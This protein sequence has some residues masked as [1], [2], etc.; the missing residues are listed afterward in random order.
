MSFRR[1]QLSYFVTVAQEGQITRAARKLHMAQPALSQ[2][3][4]QL[5]SQLGV[6]LLERH[7]RGV[8][9]TEAG[10]VFLEKAKAAL[11]A[12]ADAAATGRSLARMA[13]GSI[14][15]G[16][17]STPPRMFAAPLFEGFARTH[18][19]VTVS[20]RELRFPSASTA[21]WLAEV[22]MA[23]CFSP[24]PDPGVVTQALWWEP[25]WVLLHRDHALAERQAVAVADVL[26]EPFYGCHPSVDPI[27]AGFWTLDDHRG[28]PPTRLTDH[29]P[30]TSLELIAA[31][32]SGQAVR[33]FT[34]TTA[35]TLATFLPELVAVALSDAKPA[36]CAL[37]RSTSVASPPIAAFFEAARA[38]DWAGAEPGP[39]ERRFPAHGPGLPARQAS[40]TD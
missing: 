17:L 12:E 30:I 14:E 2:A 19:L 40:R 3:I 37:A 38:F 5:E 27:W 15:M 34:A 18:P 25:R 33:A 31:I 6:E 29:Q 7:A 23:F 1:G 10:E 22:D 16:F 11:N 21:D 4:A 8:S 13:K 32:S 9:L 35:K 20:F 24:T 39:S 36:E 28:G 26:D